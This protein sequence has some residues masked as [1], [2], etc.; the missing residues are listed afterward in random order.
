[1][2]LAKITKDVEGAPFKIGQ[3]VTIMKIID[4]S[5][6]EYIGI[7]DADSIEDAVEEYFLDKDATVIYLA[8]EGCC[9]QV[10]PQDPMIGLLIDGDEQEHAFWAEELIIKVEEA[11]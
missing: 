10:Y 9:G 11:A 1:M 4:G 5:T 2:P 8:Y 7:G 6:L 3:R